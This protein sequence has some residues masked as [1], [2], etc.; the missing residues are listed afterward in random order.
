[1]HIVQLVPLPP[2]HL[3]FNKFQNGLSFWYRPT[4]LSWKKAIKRV[5]L[6]LYLCMHGWVSF[7]VCCTDSKLVDNSAVYSHQVE[8]LSD[9]LTMSLMIGV[10]AMCML[11]WQLTHQLHVAVQQLQL[12][13]PH[14][15]YLP[16]PPV[17]CPQPAVTAEVRVQC[18]TIHTCLLYTSPSPRDS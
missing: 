10:D 17:Y 6:L 7:R 4:R 2:H 1:M 13:V 15:I 5:L 12:L 9:S 11:L 8:A 18:S 3:C 16:A 14:T